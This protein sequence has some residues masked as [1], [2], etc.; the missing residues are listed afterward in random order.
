MN[1][2]DFCYWLKGYLELTYERQLTLEQLSVIKEHL[3]LVFNK[4]TTLMIT[5]DGYRVV[6]TNHVEEGAIPHLTC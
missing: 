3:D 4:K 6:P 5:P 2:R 1:E